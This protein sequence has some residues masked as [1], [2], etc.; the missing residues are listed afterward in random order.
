[1]GPFKRYLHVIS[2]CNKHFK[3]KLLFNEKLSILRLAIK[4]IHNFMIKWTRDIA[5][6][7]FNKQRK[8]KTQSIQLSIIS[9]VNKSPGACA[10]STS[11]TKNTYTHYTCIYMIIIIPISIPISIY[12]KNVFTIDLFSSRIIKSVQLCG[13][14]V[15]RSPSPPSQFSICS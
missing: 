7:V 2:E 11:H 12:V 4:H 6:N 9:W 15:I 13:V 5:R 14:H 8:Q 3:R 1:M 10:Q